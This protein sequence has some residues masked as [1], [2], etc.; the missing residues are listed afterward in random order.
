MSSKLYVYSLL[1]ARA[2]ALADAQA[3]ASDAYA[4]DDSGN[5]SLGI[6]DPDLLD[7]PPPMTYDL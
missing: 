1:Y 4:S 5:D 2:L 7:I 3:Q 6:D